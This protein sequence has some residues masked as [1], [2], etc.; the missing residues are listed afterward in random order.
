MPVSAWR[1]PS[2]DYVPSD[3]LGPVDMGNAVLSKYPLTDAKRIQL[4]LIQDQSALERYFYLKRNLLRVR[5][6]LGDGKSV[7]AVNTHTSAFARDGTK[8]KQ[9][10][11]FLAELDELR[12]AGEL[13]V[14]GGDLNTLPPGSETVTDF[15]DSVCTDEDFQAD[16]YSRESDWLAPLYD[17]YGSAV[18]LQQYQADNTPFF[19]HTTDK[20]GFFNRK[21]D[22]LFSNGT[23]R[24]GV[25]YQREV[26]GGDP[27]VL[28]DHA[29][30]G[31]TLV[32]DE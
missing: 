6:E 1:T 11:R 14:G 29:P 28:S 27:M 25:T 17:S 4:P 7:R 24:D 22:Y 8:K 10:D 13:V 2:W 20:A 23:F 12:A 19:T 32:L 31:V 15:P 26:A 18:S 16:D 21:L 5:I 9:L 3:G 30:L